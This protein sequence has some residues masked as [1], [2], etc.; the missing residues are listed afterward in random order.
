MI[1][2]FV[3]DAVVSKGYNGQDALKYSEDGK[4]VRFRIG[5]KVYDTRCENNTRWF[6]IGVKAFGRF[7]S[8]L[9]KC[10]SKTVHM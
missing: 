7:V 10:S 9:R 6:N 5:K 1:K 2:A 4:S 3:T 8:V